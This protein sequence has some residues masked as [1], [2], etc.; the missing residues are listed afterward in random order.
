[1]ST[2]NRP[3]PDFAA[4]GEEAARVFGRMFPS[5]AQVEDQLRAALSHARAVGGDGGAL[6]AGLVEVLEVVHG[7][8]LRMGKDPDAQI[9]L[10][11]A[12]EVITNAISRGMGE[13]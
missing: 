3:D 2:P 5:P 12:R 13:G 6:A 11:E 9:S 8:N 1:M 4:I 10:A 7:W